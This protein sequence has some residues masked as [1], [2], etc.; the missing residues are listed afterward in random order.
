LK[1]TESN[2]V[3]G[4]EAAKNIVLPLVIAKVI[5]LEKRTSLKKCKVLRGLTYIRQ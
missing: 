5:A 2:T 4:V 3:G 1:D